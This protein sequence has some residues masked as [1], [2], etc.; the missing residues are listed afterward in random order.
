MNRF[1]SKQIQDNRNYLELL[2]Q[3]FPCIGIAASEV[4]NLKAIMNLPKGTE[5]Y[6]NQIY[7][8]LL[9]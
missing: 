6:L 3:K 9:H 2:S 4:I 8:N 5:H 7:K 1:T